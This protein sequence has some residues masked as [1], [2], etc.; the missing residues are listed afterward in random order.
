MKL[1]KINLTVIAIMFLSVIALMFYYYN[2]QVNECTRNP[3][4]YASKQ[5]QE[6]TGYEFIGT[7]F[8]LTPVNVRS[9]LVVFNSSGYTIQSK[10]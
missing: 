5:F 3:L 7:G 9:P 2:A 4:A 8:F 1:D 10:G 6:N